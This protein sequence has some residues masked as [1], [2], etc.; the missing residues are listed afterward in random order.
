MQQRQERALD[1]LEEYADIVTGDI[2][3]LRLRGDDFFDLINPW[4]EQ[5]DLGTGLPRDEKTIKK[6]MLDV[7]ESP[8][9]AALA[10]QERYR[11]LLE[12][13]QRSL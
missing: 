3:P 11:S 4:L 1:M 6:S 13:L 12:R 7:V 5:L 8:A 10:Q 9:F 2:Y